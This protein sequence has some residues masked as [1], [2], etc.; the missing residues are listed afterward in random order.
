MGAQITGQMIERVQIPSK[1]H[2]L[3][4]TPQS[5]HLL[6]GQVDMRTQKHQYVCGQSFPVSLSSE[7]L[8]DG[9]E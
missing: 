6:V 7:T 5:H 4:L 3:A 2:A 9:R 8:F 1:D